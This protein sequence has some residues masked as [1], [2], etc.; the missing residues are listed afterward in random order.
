[1]NKV[2]NVLDLEGHFNSILILEP[3]IIDHPLM[4]FLIIVSAL[5]SL[6]SCAPSK[7]LVNLPS[8]SDNAENSTIYVIRDSRCANLV[9][10]NIYSN[11]QQI[12][13]LKSR[14]YLTWSTNQKSINLLSE[15]GPSSELHLYLKPGETYYVRHGF[16]IFEGVLRATPTLSQILKEEGKAI[17][18]KLKSPVVA[19]NL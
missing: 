1:M 9:T 2:S 12:G 6:I 19:E 13:K 8:D 15:A 3:H 5:I 18:E 16:N 17:L 7:Q 4:K 14:S 10:A 11:E